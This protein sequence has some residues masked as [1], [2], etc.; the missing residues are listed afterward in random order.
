MIYLNIYSCF[1]KRAKHLKDKPQY[2]MDAEKIK[3]S[4]LIKN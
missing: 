1:I 2:L 4:Y 3:A